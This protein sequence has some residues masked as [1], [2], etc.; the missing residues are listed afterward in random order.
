MEATLVVMLMMAAREQLR[1]LSA[2]EAD[3]FFKNGRKAC[4][5]Q[6][7]THALLLT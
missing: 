6:S 2:A 7:S 5:Q 1:R 3:A 4:H